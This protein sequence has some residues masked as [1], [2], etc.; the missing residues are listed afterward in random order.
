MY[1]L[2]SISAQRQTYQ[3]LH[4][5]R[6]HNI[7]YDIQGQGSPVLLLP[8]FSTV[9]S[10]TELTGIAQ[11]LAPHFQVIT[12]DW[13]GFGES[14]RPKIQY[15]RALYQTLLQAFVQECCP[16]P[17]TLVAAG[18][19]AGYAMHLAQAQPEACSKLFLIAP[20]WKGPL[21]AMGAP[22]PV[23]SG[24][25]NLVR[26]PLLGQALYGLNTHPE[27]LKWMYQRHVYV[28]QDKLT[29]EFIN[30]KH[31]ITQQ[32]GAR[33]APAAFVTGGLDPMSDREEWLT[34]GRSL[35]LPLKMLI[36]EQ[37]PPKST[38]EMEALATLP[39]IQNQRI[40]GT[41]GTYEEYAA[42]VGQLTLAFCQS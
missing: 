32:P 22:I 27:F 34:V 2:T 25:R 30:A 13:L 24:I 18:H 14:D 23:A 3:W 19:A 42:E 12:L 7:A 10:R 36:P 20:T 31:Q 21:R 26:S 15:N 5:G 16:Q 29:P 11:I 1:S 33:F 38:A 37:A 4:Q 35:S 39:Q 40:P 17:L 8:A 41:L 6:S 28:D 9:S